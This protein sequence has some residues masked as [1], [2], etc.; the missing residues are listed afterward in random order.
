MQM[1]LAG[2]VRDI[3]VQREA[4]GISTHKEA[5]LTLFVNDRKGGWKVHGV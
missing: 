1:I 3:L 4:E 5:H 2:G